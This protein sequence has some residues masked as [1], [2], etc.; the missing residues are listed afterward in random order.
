MIY[1]IYHPIGGMNHECI[2]GEF[3]YTKV[4]EVK[5]DSLE[6]AFIFS[7]NDLARAYSNF[8]VRSTSVGDIIR[9]QGS[10]TCFLVMNQGF[11]EVLN[12]WIT[13]KPGNYPF[14]ETF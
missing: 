14:P 9:P 13:F 7:Q 1:E 5:A 4:A 12:N 10:D 11:F 3:E 8:G 2:P 6:S